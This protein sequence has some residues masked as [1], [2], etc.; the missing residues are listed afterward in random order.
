MLQV[1]TM[2]TAPF[3]GMVRKMRAKS[4]LSPDLIR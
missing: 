4:A 1:V 2:A 3:V